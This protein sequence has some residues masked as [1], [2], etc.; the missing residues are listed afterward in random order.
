MSQGGPRATSQSC[1]W[2]VDSGAPSLQRSPPSHRVTGAPARSP[3]R[4][5]SQP[6]RERPANAGETSAGRP[7]TRERAA[8]FREKS[9][10]LMHRAQHVFRCSAPVA[11]QQRLLCLVSRRA[12][13]HLVDRGLRYLARPRASRVGQRDP[14]MHRKRETR[15]IRF[16]SIR[17]HRCRIRG[18]LSSRPVPTPEGSSALLVRLYLGTC[19]QATLSS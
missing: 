10:P 16:F 13:V 15:A 7:T 1:R 4:A 19:Y 3:A 14:T 11:A 8:S 5:I 18:D 2:R 6:L 12:S 9:P 17:R